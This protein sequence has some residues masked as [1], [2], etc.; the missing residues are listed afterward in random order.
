MPAPAT[1]SPE[2]PDAAMERAVSR[3][4]RAGVIMAVVLGVAGIGVHIARGG[5]VLPNV[6]K[7]SGEPPDLTSIRA[8]VRAAAR[9]DGL[10]L[11][12][13]AIVVLILT[14]LARVLVMFAGFARARDR[15]YVGISLIVLAALVYGLSA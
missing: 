1:P 5:A 14:P 6:S 9:L 7:F 15:L 4:L 8:I 11:V 2:R 12:Q 10:A 13:L 3:V